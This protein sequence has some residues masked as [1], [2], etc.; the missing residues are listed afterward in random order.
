MQALLNG[1]GGLRIT[2]GGLKLLQPHLPESVGQLRLRRIAWRGGHLTIT[3]GADAQTVALLDG[4]PLCLTDA[5][6]ENSQPLA[7]GGPAAQLDVATYAYPAL[8]AACA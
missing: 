7:P 6:G 1:W 5:N 2:V 4:P 3:V 8:L